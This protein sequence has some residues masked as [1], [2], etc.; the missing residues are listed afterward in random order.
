ME[1]EEERCRGWWRSLKVCCWAGLGG[2][3]ERVQLGG[4]LASCLLGSLKLGLGADRAGLQRADM[5]IGG[6]GIPS[7]GE[8]GW[9]LETRDAELRARPLGRD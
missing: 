8:S 1:A 3:R 9:T 4:G 5:M 6:E 7:R 2:L